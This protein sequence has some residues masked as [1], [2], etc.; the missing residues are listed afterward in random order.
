MRKLYPSK[1]CCD[2]DVTMETTVKEMFRG[3][4][5]RLV[6]AKAIHHVLGER[7]FWHWSDQTDLKHVPIE[8]G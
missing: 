7:R 4:P 2:A 8:E 6:R 5:L 1:Q 3:K